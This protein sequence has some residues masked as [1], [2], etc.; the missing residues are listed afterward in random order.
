MATS[1]TIGTTRISTAKMVEKAL[2]RCGLAPQ[3]ITPEI[4]ETAKEDLFMFLMGL[5]NR[6]LNLWC[7]DQKLMN[8]VVGKKTYLLPVGTTDV[9][10][11]LFCVSTRPD[12]TVVTAATDASVTFTEDTP[13]VRFGVKFSVLPTV[14]FDFQTSVDGFT[15][16]TIQT[17]TEFPAINEYA[18]F[19]LN[20]RLTG[21]YFRLYSTTLGTVSDL[22][23]ASEV[24]ETPLS[25]FN[26]DDYANQPN[27]DQLSG[28][29]VSYWFEKLVEPQITAWP[30]PS[31]DTAHLRL[32]R[33]RQIQD[34]GTLTQEL[35]LPNRW[36]EAINW[37][38]AS[39]L[40]FEIIGV[41]PERRKEVIMMA[42]SMTIEVEGGETD[43]S[44]TYFAPNISVYTRG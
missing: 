18:W 10:N 33:Y 24:R 7:V 44:P 4:V 3:A 20:T 34:I 1:G 16:T 30:V 38:L 31:I 43:S 2:R 21:K 5:S 17:V 40:A 23:L 14:S 27:K 42:N 19:D 36:F 6:G 32:F 8:L 39:R 29:V 41:D 11:L 26:R 37:H 22:Y 35:E 15:W 12:Y 9:L 28:T 25:A 13:V